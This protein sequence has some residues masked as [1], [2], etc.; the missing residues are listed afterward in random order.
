METYLLFIIFFAVNPVP[1]VM[2]LFLEV[3]LKIKF[4]LRHTIHR[5][6]FIHLDIRLVFM[7]MGLV[8]FRYSSNNKCYLV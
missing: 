4:S 7:I 8:F 1:C 2:M 6:L 3:G 5:A